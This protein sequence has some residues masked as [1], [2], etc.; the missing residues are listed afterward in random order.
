MTFRDDYVAAAEAVVTQVADL[1]DDSWDAPALGSWSGR[2]LVGHLGSMFTSVVEAC[3]RPATSLGL[4][5]T[6]GYYAFRRTLAPEVY[7]TALAAVA[8]VHASDA[9]ALGDDPVTTLRAQFARAVEALANT[10]DDDLVTTPAGGM[11]LRD[12]LPTRTFELATHGVDLEAAT[13][14]RVVLP[15]EVLSS[16]VRVAAATAVEIGDGRAVLLAL[17]GREDLPPGYCA[18]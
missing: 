2:M 5:R 15:P 14:V 12:W 4:P 18:I 1:P 11:R 17:T 16:A 8:E 13:G 10:G 6:G 9:A 3:S 7:E